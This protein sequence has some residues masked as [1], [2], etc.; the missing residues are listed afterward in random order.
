MRFN[1]AVAGNNLQ[2]VLTKMNASAEIHKSTDDISWAHFWFDSE[3]SLQQNQEI[4]ETSGVRFFISDEAGNKKHTAGFPEWVREQTGWT[5]TSL[6][7]DF[8]AYN[9]KP[10]QNWGFYFK[11]ELEAYCLNLTGGKIVFK[12]LKVASEEIS[13]TGT[14]KGS[15]VVTASGKEVWQSFNRIFTNHTELSDIWTKIYLVRTDQYE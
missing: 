3:R 2:E 5:E 9:S 6:T 1:V 7:F 15:K 13:G 11:K 10:G 14:A 12:A 4:L 8:W